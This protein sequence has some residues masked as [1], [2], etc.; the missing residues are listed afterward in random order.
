M[1]YFDEADLPPPKQHRARV[2]LEEADDSG[3]PGFVE[4]VSRDRRGILVRVRAEMG[5][6]TK[7][8]AD[9]ALALADKV[10]NRAR[11]LAIIAA[12]A[13]G[14]LGGVLLTLLVQRLLKKRKKGKGKKKRAQLTG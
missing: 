10:T 1:V 7:D 2:V 13:G 14:V 4:R 3:V 9:K 5:P 8:T 6:E 12:L 11:M